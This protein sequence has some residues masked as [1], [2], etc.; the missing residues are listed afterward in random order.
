[1]MRDMSLRR[2]APMFAVMRRKRRSAQMKH[3]LSESL[4]H[5]KR[6][7]TIAAHETSASVSPKIQAAVDTVKP[8]ASKAKDTASTSWESAVSTLT[9]LLVAAAD[10][11]RL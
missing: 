6:A 11:A 1:M 5:F 10:S 7:A 9:P 4:D 3:E 8:A 2:R